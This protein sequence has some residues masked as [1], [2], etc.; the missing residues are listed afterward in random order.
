MFAEVIVDIVH[1]DLARS[2]T[3]TVPDGM[4]LQIGQ[5]VEVPFGYRSKEGV[6]IALTETCGKDLDPARIKPVTAT[7]EDYAAILPQL[8][9]LAKSMAARSHCPLAETLR[10]MLPAEMRGGRV[11]VKTET[12]ARSLVPE[13]ELEQVRLKLGRS[14]R[15][16]L[17][18]ELLSDGKPHTISELKVL[19]KDP[20][21]PLREMT[22]AGYVVMEQRE[23]LRVPEDWARPAKT[24]DPPLTPGQ[25]EVLQVLTPA[26]RKGSGSFLLHGVTGSGKTEVYIRLVRQALAMGKSA[27]ILVP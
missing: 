11:H 2:F 18:L 20:T 24:E 21:Q 6:V 10:L 27:M 25:E 4:T 15:K 13:A 7:L 3:Y 14:R 19:V 12:V 5:R 17:L 23:L 8:L 26:L 22:E 9:E 1:D 16:K